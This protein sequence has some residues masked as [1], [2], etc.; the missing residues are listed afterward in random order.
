MC[1]DSYGV[2]R[3]DMCT[4]IRNSHEELDLWSSNGMSPN[5]ISIQWN[6]S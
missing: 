1:N 4:E 3:K 2:P 6:E 5:R